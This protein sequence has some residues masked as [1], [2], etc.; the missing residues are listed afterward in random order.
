MTAAASCAV[1]RLELRSRTGDVR[2]VVPPGRYQLDA[3]SDVGDRA[4]RGV[5]A[6]DD[7]PFQIQA[8]S[9]A[10]NVTVETSG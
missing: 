6:A 3:E 1:E 2:A 10:G 8:L 5:T 7:A 4:V 9:S